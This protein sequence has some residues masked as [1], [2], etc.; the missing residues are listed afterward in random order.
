MSSLSEIIA[1]GSAVMQKKLRS[2]EKARL[3]TE[4]QRI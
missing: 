4:I 1:C 3:E 2:E